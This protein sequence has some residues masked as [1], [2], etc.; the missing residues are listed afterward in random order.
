MEERFVNALFTED[1]RYKI[2]TCII[3]RV[4]ISERSVFDSE[5]I[6]GLISVS[7]I[8][9]KYVWKLVTMDIPKG[10]TGPHVLSYLT[11]CSANC[12]IPVKFG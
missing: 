3:G 2:I 7:I 9:S 5:E 11:S 6:K 4:L 1:V 12:L 8:F 10:T